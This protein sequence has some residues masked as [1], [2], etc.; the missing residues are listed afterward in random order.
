MYRTIITFILLSLAITGQ[1]I[2]APVA[3]V[4]VVD[5]QRAVSE[6]R[7]GIAAR[8]AV[9][10]KT[11][12]YNAELKSKLTDIERLRAELKEKL[13][14]D[15][16]TSKEELLQKK[17]REFQYRQQEVKDDL[18]QLESEYL[19]KIINKFGVLL[20]K[21]G[22]NGNFSAILDRSAGVLYFGKEN[23]IT[24]QLVKLADEDY[25]KR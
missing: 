8:T 13:S 2:A 1:A 10:K 16:R 24:A 17:I 3:R 12:Q 22:E 5:L 9:Q 23:D 6:C 11:E 21:I 4:G 20:G 14:T 15:D 19:K 7:E 18:K 25:A